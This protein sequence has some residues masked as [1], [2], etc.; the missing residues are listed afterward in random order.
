MMTSKFNKYLRTE[1]EV[2]R[3]KDSTNAMQWYCAEISTFY[4]W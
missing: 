2:S 1:L 4:G 3:L